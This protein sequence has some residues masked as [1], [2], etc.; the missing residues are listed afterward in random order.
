VLQ[1]GLGITFYKSDGRPGLL[2]CASVSVSVSH[3]SVSVSVS[4]SVCVESL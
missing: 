3:V 2:V 4:L 1:V